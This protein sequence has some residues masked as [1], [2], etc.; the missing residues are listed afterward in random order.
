MIFNFLGLFLRLFL[1]LY[2]IKGFLIVVT[3][4]SGFLR[5]SGFF[6]VCALGAVRVLGSGVAGNVYIPAIRVGGDLGTVLLATIGGPM[7]QALLV[8][9]GVI[10]SRVDW[11]MV[12]SCFAAYLAFVAGYVNGGVGV[13]FGDVFSVDLFRPDAGRAGG[14]VFGVFLIYG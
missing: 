14:V 12:S 4:V 2:D 9:F 1:P 10:F 8:D 13:F 11:R 6:F 7:G 3:V 5:A